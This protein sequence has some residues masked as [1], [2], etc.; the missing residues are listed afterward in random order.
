MLT[1]FGNAVLHER[2]LQFTHTMAKPSFSPRWAVG[3]LAQTP[4]TNINV[5]FLGS[6]NDSRRG[7]I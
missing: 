3:K 2:T 7:Y 5:V 4:Y 1:D 6:R